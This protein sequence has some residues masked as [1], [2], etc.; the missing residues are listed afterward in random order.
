MGFFQ[1]D[2]FDNTIYGQLVHAIPRNMSP[3]EEEYFTKENLTDP[4][5]SNSVFENHDSNTCIEVLAPNPFIRKTNVTKSLESIT[6][7]TIF[8]EV[9][10]Q[11][12]APPIAD[13]D[14][15]FFAQY[16]SFFY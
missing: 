8:A 7:N 15:D 16:V 11:N 4:C 10:E 5:S 14:N 2:T 6:L 13:F 9:D 1:R 12:I 3:T